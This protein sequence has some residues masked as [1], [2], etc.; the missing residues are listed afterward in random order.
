VHRV[1]VVAQLFEHSADMVSTGDPEGRITYTNAATA[2]LTGYAPEELIGESYAKIVAPEYVNVVAEQIRRLVSGEAVTAVYEVEI[3]CKDGERVPVEVSAT[4]MLDD[5]G[6]HVGQIAISRDLRDRRAVEEQLR[7]AQKMEAVGRVAR[8]IAHDFNNVLLVM[9]GFGEL[10][11]TKLPDDHPASGYAAKIVAEAERAAAMTRRLLVFGRPEALE[12]EPID[13]EETL[14][15]MLEALHMLVGDTVEFEF[16][17]GGDGERVLADRGALQQIVFNLVANAR[18]AMSDGGT[19]TLET[20]RVTLGVLEA[21]ALL[22]LRPGRYRLLRVS[23]TGSGMD[24]ETRERVFDPFFTTKEAGSG[25]GLAIVYGLV[26]QQGGHIHVESRPGEGT[27][28]AVYLPEA[29]S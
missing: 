2:R 4:A 11:A 17:P 1:D 14:A 6:S 27:T 9:R 29:T 5:D 18:D 8:G 12:P 20:R 13:L 7:Q 24:E 16:R 22:A 23:D 15:S 21:E 3:V 19:L 28:F 10:I 26:T 25:L